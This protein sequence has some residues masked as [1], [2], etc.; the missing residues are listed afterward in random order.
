MEHHSN[1]VPWQMLAEEKGCSY[2]VMPMNDSGELILDQIEPMFNENTK[3]VVFNHISNALGTIN[4]VKELVSMARKV[5]A[6]VLLDGAQSTAHLSVDVQ[7][8]DVDF[9]FSSHKIYGP[10]GVG[11]LYGKTELLNS[12]PPW[13]GGGDMIENVSFEKTTFAAPPRPDLKQARQPLQRSSAWASR[14]IIFWT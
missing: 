3:L 14:L 7:D 5:G 12:M 4:P 9:A 13:Q 2:K 6:L 10:S 1:I 11:V 8:L